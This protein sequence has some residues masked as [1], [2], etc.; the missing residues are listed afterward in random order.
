MEGIYVCNYFISDSVSHFGL[1]V[2]HFGL[3]VFIVFI[4]SDEPLWAGYIYYLIYGATLGR[5]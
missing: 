4:V 1:V 2:S 5:M 3:D